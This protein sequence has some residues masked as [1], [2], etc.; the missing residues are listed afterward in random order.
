MTS[1]IYRIYLFARPAYSSVEFVD[2][3]VICGVQNATNDQNAT[4][5]P[6]SERRLEYHDCI[7]SSIRVFNFKNNENFYLFKFRKLSPT[8]YLKYK[9]DTLRVDFKVYLNSTCI[10]F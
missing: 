4:T 2:L 7:L 10:G 6:V 1:R 8:S 9:S 5:L 3:H